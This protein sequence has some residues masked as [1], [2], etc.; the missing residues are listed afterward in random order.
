MASRDLAKADQRIRGVYQAVKL[1][2]ERRFAGYELRPICTLRSLDEQLVEFKAGRSQ[3]DGVSKKGPHNF[4][5]SRAIDFGIF[6]KSDG[7][8]LDDLVS[9]G[10]FSAELRNAMFWIVGLL[11]QR[12]GA[13]WG[14]DWDGDGIPVPVDPTE[15]FNDDDHIEIVEAAA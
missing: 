4:D 8:Y 5:P 1:I 11:A 14:G 3:I 6:R 13:R 10:Q 9:K 15:H 2:F 7:A 12:N